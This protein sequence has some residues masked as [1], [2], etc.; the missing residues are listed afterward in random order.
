MERGAVGCP[1][2]QAHCLTW[3]RRSGSC[4]LAGVT[5]EQQPVQR[6][7]PMEAD[8]DSVDEELSRV[9]ALLGRLEEAPRSVEV[10]TSLNRSI[11]GLARHRTRAVFEFLH[12]LADLPVLGRVRDQNGWPC[13]AAVLST[14]LELG[15]PYALELTP[16]DLQYVRDHAP[17]RGTGWLNV[18]SALAITSAVVNVPATLLMLVFLAAQPLT[19]LRFMLPTGL[20]ALHAIAMLGTLEPKRPQA[21]NAS[22]LQGLGAVGLLALLV[23]ALSIVSLGEL[24]ACLLVSCLPMGLASAAALVAAH[25]LKKNDA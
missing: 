13:R 17:G 14:W 6:V 19:E 5:Q 1:F 15:Y 23:A 11:T 20:M 8:S 25:R 7:V 18:T 9:K 21:T 2:G 12:E 10:A 22:W 3:L 4:R 16:E 24:G